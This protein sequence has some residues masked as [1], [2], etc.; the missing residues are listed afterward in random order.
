MKKT[1]IFSVLIYIVMIFSSGGIAIAQTSPEPNVSGYYVSVNG[2]PTGPLDTSGLRQL[3]SQGQ[4]TKNSLVWKAGM[5]DWA[6]AGTVN[7]LAPLL[8]PEL[9]P[10]LPTVQ[11]PPPLPSTEAPPPLPAQA[12][13]VEASQ[14]KPVQTEA[15]QTVA[16]QPQVRTSERW[17]NSFAP[18]LRNNKVFLS[19]G[20][21]Y[22][23]L[24]GWSIGIP[25]LSLTLDFKL[26]RRVPLTLGFTGIFS[27]KTFYYLTQYNIGIGGRVMYHFGPVKNLDL[28]VGPTFGWVIR[29]Y[30]GNYYGSSTGG[31]FLWGV[32]AGMGYFFAG[33]P[34]GLYTE[35]GYNG[36]QFVSAGLVFKF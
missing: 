32:S 4:L 23:P 17:Y 29:F 10:P 9:P 26:S 31:Y 7:E 25:P 36:L 11:A 8:P 16:A 3:A 24:S 6:P 27:T 15:P 34:F 20:V 21:G 35:L 1:T 19:T 12:P 13:Q 14:S 30:G 28:Y 5:S 33:G 2:Q 18:G 22:G